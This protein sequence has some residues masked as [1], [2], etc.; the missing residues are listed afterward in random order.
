MKTFLSAMLRSYRFS[1]RPVFYGLIAL[2]FIVFPA[3]PAAGRAMPRDR[4][5]RRR[6]MPDLLY[7]NARR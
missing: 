6:S 2:L 5:R 4:R 7:T 3:D 1:R